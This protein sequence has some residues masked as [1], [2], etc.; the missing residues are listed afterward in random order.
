MNNKHIV[1]LSVIL[2]TYN[3]SK[4]LYN[5]LSQLLN[6]N[7]CP[8]EIVVIDQT[9]VHDERVANFLENLVKE[10][11][12]KYIYQDFP[13]PNVARN[14]GI[15]ESR[16]DILLILNDD[17][18]IHPD[19]I[20]AHFKNFQDPNIAAVSGCV[21]EE[22]EMLTDK[23]PP[24][25]YRKYTGW[26]YFPLSFSKKTEVIN[27]NS[28]NLSIRR[29][30]ILE[31][32]GF[33]ENFFKA[34]YDDSE[35]SLRVHKICLEKGLRTIHDPGPAI[36]H[37]LTKA[38]NRLGGKNEYVIADRYT[39]TM[40]LYYFLGNFGIYAFF[41]IGEAMRKCIFRKKNILSPVHLFTALYE[42]ILGLKKAFVLIMNGRNLGL[43]PVVP[44]GNRKLPPLF[45]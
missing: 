22:G 28:C 15:R 9:K 31:A 38:G 23:F 29:E 10:N 34:S 17:I 6:Q 32:G 30:I 43:L 11:K 16:G 12:I 45:I 21:L 3:R 33:D 24:R 37:L 27:L 8:L 39:W 13:H 40:F 41:D 20:G 18:I 44:S 26:M 36:T 2:P 5:T 19:F 42:F 14:R 1:S 35:L 4:D 7:P 25:Y